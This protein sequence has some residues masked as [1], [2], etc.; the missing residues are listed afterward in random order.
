MQKGNHLM[1]IKSDNN[2]MTYIQTTLKMQRFFM[3]KIYLIKLKPSFLKMWEMNKV[4]LVVMGRVDL[5]QIHQWLGFQLNFQQ[6]ITENIQ[7]L[8]TGLMVA[9]KEV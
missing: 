3:E 5:S 7:H 1:T 6:N 8:K 9:F 4:A 2:S